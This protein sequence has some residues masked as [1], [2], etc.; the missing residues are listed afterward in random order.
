MAAEASCRASVDVKRILRGKIYEKMLAPVTLFL[1][2]SRVSLKA[3]VILLICVPLI[4]LSIV[5]VQKIAG[6]LFR[7][8]WDI[9]PIWEMSFWKICRALPH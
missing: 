5:A 3:S 7:R 4:P 2:L 1:V 8:Y 6:R 9:I